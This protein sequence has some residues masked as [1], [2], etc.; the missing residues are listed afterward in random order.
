[1]FHRVNQKGKYY[2]ARMHEFVFVVWTSQ[3]TALLWNMIV[4]Q[5]AMKLPAFYGNG[6]SIIVSVSN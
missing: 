6:K 2:T 1:M 4:T 3:K 5:L